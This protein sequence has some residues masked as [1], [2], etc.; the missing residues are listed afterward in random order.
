[1]STKFSE[2]VVP[3]TDLKVNP[4]RVVKHV[5][6]VHRPVLLTSR[7]RGVAVVQSVVD[8][9]EAQEER[10]FMRAVVEGLADIEAGREVSIEEARRRLG[11]S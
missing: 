10:A 4:G 7:G 1:M 5:A 3:L 9:E 2:D 11:L 6:E 8:Y